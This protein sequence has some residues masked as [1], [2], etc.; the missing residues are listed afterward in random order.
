MKK[1]GKKVRKDAGSL[2]MYTYCNCT[3]CACTVSL[4]STSS[5]YTNQKTQKD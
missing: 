5:K 3:N 4:N 2:Q 1:L